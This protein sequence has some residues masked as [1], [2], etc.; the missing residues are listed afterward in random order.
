MLAYLAE[1]NDIAVRAYAPLR[2]FT[3]LY[4]YVRSLL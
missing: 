1:S 3:Q 2:F 4:E